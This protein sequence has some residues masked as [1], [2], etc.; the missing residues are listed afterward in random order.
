MTLC[1]PT[2]KLGKVQPDLRAAGDL[3][4]SGG[5]VYL[6]GNSALPW[7]EPNF[8]VEADA[9]LHQSL[10]SD[11]RPDGGRKNEMKGRQR[12]LSEAKARLSSNSAIAVP[13]L[14]ISFQKQSL[15][16]RAAS[17]QRSPFYQRPMSAGTV[18]YGVS[19]RILSFL[20]P[21]TKQ[22]HDVLSSD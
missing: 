4:R 2:G 12:C 1:H 8:S 6:G 9:Q 21:S 14:T 18:L 5:A 3:T 15:G 20:R 10:C 7:E 13:A 22:C 11:R 19:P 17:T 16:R